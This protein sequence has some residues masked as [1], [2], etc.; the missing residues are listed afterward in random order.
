MAGE[1]LC[2]PPCADFVAGAALREI[3]WQAQHRANLHVQISWQA[4]CV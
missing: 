4:Q 3:S 2:E 1:T